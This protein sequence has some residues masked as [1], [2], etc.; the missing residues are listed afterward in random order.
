MASAGFFV[1]T[2]LIVQP[3]KLSIN[4]LQSSVDRLATAMER[5]QGEVGENNEELARAEEKMKTLFAN[6]AALSARVRHIEERCENCQCKG[7]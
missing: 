1:A 5:V 6:D 2:Y 7:D 4:A 3:L